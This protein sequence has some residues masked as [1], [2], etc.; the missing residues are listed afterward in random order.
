MQLIHRRGNMTYI[1]LTPREKDIEGLSF[2]I[3]KPSE[4]HLETFVERVNRTSV[5]IA[6]ID[7]IESGHVTVYPNDMRQMD[8]WIRS[9]ENYTNAPHQFT[10]LLYGIVTLVR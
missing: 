3:Y 2:N 9:R 5:L 4:K 1:N 8:Q 7:N 10:I 6:R